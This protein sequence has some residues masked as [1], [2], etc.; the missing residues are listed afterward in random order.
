MAN[1]SDL[2]IRVSS[3]L[4]HHQRRGRAGR[5]IVALGCVAA[6]VLAFTISPLRTVPSSQSGTAQ[7]ATDD[8]KVTGEPPP[9]FEVVSIR[10]DRSADQQF[11]FLFLPGRFI[12]TGITVKSLISSAY[13][14]KDFQVSGGPDWI[15]SAR[16]D[17]TAKEPD[18]IAAEMPKL[19]PE[20]SREE[21]GLLL[22]SM[23]A[24]RFKLAVSHDT[25]SLP[26]YALVIAKSGPK[27]HEAKPG[28]TYPN[29]LNLNGR[30]NA[31]MVRVL[32]GQI[33]GQGISMSSPPVGLVQLLS[34]QVE[35]DVIDQTGL[36]GIYDFTLNWT[37]EVRSAPVAPAPPGSSLGVANPPEADSSGPSLFTALQEQ[38]GLK[39]ES[40]KAPA[41][42]IVIDHIERPSEN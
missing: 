25:R 18:A 12:A 20:Q 34:E 14:V 29:G 16:F 32:P 1:R 31:G 9:S 6:T 24:D 8:L 38:L 15:R 26:A 22:Q 42:V 5:C 37:P 13:H 17:I 27:L 23:L 21:E 36:R 7:A 11:Q 3:V 28:D 2:P 41:K 35:R 19:S 40:T 39:L 30:G 33:I 10:P 4:D